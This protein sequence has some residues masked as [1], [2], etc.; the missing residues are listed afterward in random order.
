[1]GFVTPH[2]S[3]IIDPSYETPKCLRFVGGCICST[4][5]IFFFHGLRPIGVSQYPSQSVS[6]TAQVLSPFWRE[7]NS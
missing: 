1:V 2:I 3:I 4:A 5:S 7:K 6:L